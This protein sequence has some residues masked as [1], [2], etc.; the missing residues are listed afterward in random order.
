M[1]NGILLLVIGL[2]F[3]C[4]NEK[5]NEDK[6]FELTP[7]GKF[8]SLDLDDSTANISTGLQYFK[9][10]KEYL[11]NANW[12]TNSVQ[13]YDLQ[14]QKLSKELFFDYEGPNGIGDLFGFHVHSMDSI[15]LFTAPFGSRFFM[16]NSD[17]EI[18]NRIDYQI[19]EGGGS[20]F[21]HNA[22]MI[23]PP[24]IRGTLLAVNHRFP[25]NTRE[26]TS[27]K[28]ASKTFGYQ[29]DMSSGETTYFNHF[30]PAD[31]LSSGQKLVVL[32]K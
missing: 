25:G 28:L 27:E 32:N 8:L 24:V 17:G 13:I 11:F 31:Y 9:G 30:F 5:S 6:T 12:G 16:V 29:I 18:K 26:T 23:S 1:K 10:D 14:D 7:S 3:S 4:Q 21:V 2:L 19:P 15:F 22:F 20:A